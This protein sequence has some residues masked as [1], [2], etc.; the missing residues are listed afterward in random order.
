MKIKTIPALVDIDSFDD[1][2]KFVILIDVARTK[3]RN[4]EYCWVR[5][6]ISYRLRTA[7]YSYRVIGEV[8]GNRDHSTVM[9]SIEQFDNLHNYCKDA[10]FV[11]YV[12]FLESI[13]SAENLVKF[14]F[15][16][17]TTK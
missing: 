17:I 1:Y 8:L 15:E 7:G 9:W 5:H 2:S 3:C 13:V 4:Q 6:W 14:S 16:N 10:S 12:S 11:R